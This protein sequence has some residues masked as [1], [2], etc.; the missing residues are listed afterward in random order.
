MQ[1]PSALGAFLANRAPRPN[2]PRATWSVMRCPA[3]APPGAPGVVL[4]AAA[5]SLE[6]ARAEVLLP[7]GGTRPLDVVAL[8]APLA[9]PQPTLPGYPARTTQAEHW[10]VRDDGRAARLPWLSNLFP[11]DTMAS[12]GLGALEA[13][14][15]DW[16]HAWLTGR[17]DLLL[18]LAARAGVPVEALAPIVTA[19]LRDVLGVYDDALPAGAVAE[20]RAVLDAADA[21]AAGGGVASVLRAA[22]AAADQYPTR[23]GERPEMALWAVASSVAR[24]ATDERPRARSEHGRAA[25]WRFSEALQ[26]V[27]GNHALALLSDGVRARLPL[28]AV[29]LAVTERR[30]E[31]GG[32]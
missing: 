23:R 11:D 24:L 2:P 4:A 15:T 7:T 21:W 12:A 27:Q 18:R 30:A 6:D 32:A 8:T 14:E 3:D 25:L 5:P 17:G 22:A 19:G 9:A 31:P 10:F 13:G 28:S 26:R 29:L 16:R 1:T 20:L